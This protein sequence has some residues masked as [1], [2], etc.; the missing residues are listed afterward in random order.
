M[1]NF[2]YHTN[3][4]KCGSTDANALYEDGSAYCF[5]CKTIVGSPLVSENI[6]QQSMSRSNAQFV[7]GTVEMLP[8]RGLTYDTCKRY[9]YEIGTYGGKPVQIANYYKDGT[10]VGQKLRFAN[11]EFLWLGG[12][13][14][15]PL[16]GN[17]T[18]GKG[19]RIVITEG[20]LDAL[21]V[22]QAFGNSWPAVSVRNGAQGAANCLKENLAYL[23][24]FDEIVLLFDQDD[25]GQLAVQECL[26][27]LPIGKAYTAY[28]PLKDANAMVVA[29]RTQELVQAIFGA[30]PHRPDGI[31]TIAERRE[32]TTKEK[33]LS[34]FHYPY[35]LLNELTY[36]LHTKEIT[37]LCG[38]S[39]LG[40]STITREMAFSFIEAGH[41]VGFVVLEEPAEYV[42]E[43]LLGLKVNKLLRFAD[44]W[45]TQKEYL[46]ILEKDIWPMTEIYN[47]QG[48]L[49]S[50]H[51]INIIEYMAQVKACK[52]IIFD[53]I[54]LASLPEKGQDNERL[55]IDVNMANLRKLAQRL[56]IAI[57]VVSHLRKTQSGKPF[58]E[59][60]KVSSD[61][62]RG[63][64]TLKTIP[65]TIISFE[66]DQ[67]DN[68]KIRRLRILKCRFTGKVG[69]AD[70]LVYNE[71]TGRLVTKLSAITN[72]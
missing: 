35:P 42:D 27:I 26:K 58:E 17:Q 13:N 67:F 3:C 36:G 21:S 71:H 57:V 39:G 53:H 52:I 40:K 19:K 4:E 56:D 45:N 1:S 50:D 33:K 46:D 30:Q 9:G 72:Y 14:E 43:A 60:A 28:L 22:S 64:G 7:T 65:N 68:E 18:Q 47:D 11:K 32:R 6:V 41:K 59:G 31:L 62:L 20:E 10:V 66:G 69:N 16:F 8:K 63:S 25:A 61:D 34:E 2:K 54:S 55:A 38:G 15:I 24:N 51:L 5:S 70:E 12:K 44:S 23:K 37:L 29:G 48:G 49:D